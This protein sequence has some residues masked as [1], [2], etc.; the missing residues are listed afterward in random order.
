MAKAVILAG[1]QGT[2]LRPYTTVFPKPLMPIRERPVLELILRQIGK[3]GFEEAV[4]AVGYLAEL[5]IAYCGDG[6]RFGCQVTYSREEAPLGTAGCL[7]QLRDRLR[8]TFLMM[9]GDVLTTID[10]AAFLDY[11][12]REGGIATIALHRR[13]IPVDFGVVGLN[14]G[15]RIVEYTE[16]P[17]L[18]H[19]VS[20][21][22]YAF[23]PRVLD[24]IAPGKHLDFPD[25]IKA[26]IAGGEEVVGY[27][28]DG[29]WLDIGRVDDYEQA[30]AD[31]DVIYP[32]L[33]I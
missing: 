5:I 31:F 23:E 30:K 2:R 33:G 28:Y 26:L 3:A 32:H 4:V 7:G 29:Y 20:M 16:K 19:L 14:G 24:Y 18:S 25:L 21:G 6:S 27:V 12:R 22:V 8:E 11:H 17:R 15:Q 9:N 10:Y 13:E 1:G